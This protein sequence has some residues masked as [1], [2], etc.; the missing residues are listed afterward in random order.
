M[1]W[2][3][4]PSLMLRSECGHPLCGSCFMKC[5]ADAVVFLRKPV[6][7]PLHPRDGSEFVPVAGACSVGSSEVLPLFFARALVAYTHL[8]NGQRLCQWLASLCQRLEFVAEA[9]RDGDLAAAFGAAVESAA[10]DLVLPAT[11]AAKVL[12]C[13]RAEL[14]AQG[15]WAAFWVWSVT[16][17]VFSQPLFGH[18][19]E[20][21]NYLP[22]AFFEHWAHP[23]EPVLPR[24]V[25]TLDTPFFRVA[26]ALCETVAVN[27]PYVAACAHTTVFEL[28]GRLCA[29]S[30]VQ[31]R[32]FARLAAVSAG[33]L[34]VP[35]G[36][37]PA[38]A[39]SPEFTAKET[40]AV[41]A[42]LESHRRS[43]DVSAPV[44]PPQTPQAKADTMLTIRHAG[45]R[46]AAALRAECPG[47]D[48]YSWTGF[49]R[50]MHA[51]DRMVR[52]G[53]L[54]KRD[55]GA[56]AG[57]VDWGLLCAAICTVA[58]RDA[59]TYGVRAVLF[60]D[61]EPVSP[62]VASIIVLARPFEHT[63]AETAADSGGE[64]AMETGVRTGPRR[65]RDGVLAEIVRSASQAANVTVMFASSDSSM[66][67]VLDS[68]DDNDDDD[69]GG[70]GFGAALLAGRLRQA[71]AS[72]FRRNGAGD[73]AAGSLRGIEFAVDERRR[74]AWRPPG[75]REFVRG[76]AGTDETTQLAV[77]DHGLSV[78]GR[79]IARNS[80]N[81]AEM[82]ASL[83]FTIAEHSG[84][85]LDTLLLTGRCS[86][87]FL[88]AG[89]GSGPGVPYVLQN[90]GLVLCQAI[91]AD[92]VVAVA[93]EDLDDDDPT[94]ICFFTL[95]QIARIYRCSEALRPQIAGKAR[96]MRDEFA[97][98]ADVTCTSL[99]VCLADMCG[100]LRD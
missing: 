84:E 92:P 7:C 63:E 20:Y 31:G 13:A 15:G 42:M 89:G 58:P 51:L 49:G 68:D 24:A 62:R 50:D 1:C 64:H 12:E 9:R 37:P 75:L 80:T 100:G 86:L 22:R 61:F 81:L 43:G 40:A 27:G 90:T 3:Q 55:A 47:D 14:A 2:E 82:A 38:V 69:D 79:R 48:E 77:Q 26:A 97:A 28:V 41:A 33:H 19:A 10:A 73:G 52:N 72:V 96:G 39:A 74:A 95:R 17:R 98:M 16:R 53:L 46:F 45:E 44:A 57:A 30:R 6:S 21:T 87:N 70:A 35:V 66:Q 34:A 67:L 78:A 85:V 65:S 5:H 23:A 93:V 59:A 4:T 71:E 56:G 8:L 88:A 25:S 54:G 99:L 91:R 18:V 29:G 83:F 94:A 32:F 76:V 36:V 60:R 11:Y